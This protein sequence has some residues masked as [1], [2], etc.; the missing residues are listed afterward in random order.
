MSENART[1]S[2][3]Q[4]DLFCHRCVHAAHIHECTN[5]SLFA[6]AKPKGMSSYCTFWG[7]QGRKGRSLQFTHRGTDSLVHHLGKKIFSHR[8]WQIVILNTERSILSEMCILNPFF[9]HFIFS[10]P[11]IF[12][13]LGVW[14]DKP[15]WSLR[16]TIFIHNC[17]DVWLRIALEETP[18][19]P[20]TLMWLRTS[21]APLSL[22]SPLFPCFFLGGTQFNHWTIVITGI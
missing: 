12:R 18:Q 16:E 13:I 2:Q 6:D 20:F 10:S 21:L 17:T 19:I 1:Y 8:I 3:K 14:H 7:G 15:P 5:V 4:R 9:R 22:F 11:Q